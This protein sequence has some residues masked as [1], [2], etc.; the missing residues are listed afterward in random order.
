MTV[1]EDRTIERLPVNE[2]FAT[3]ADRAT[4]NRT[5]DALRARNFEA[6]VADTAAE[7]RELV[8]AMIPA[9]SEVGQGASV[10]LDSIGLTAAVAADRYVAI[11][12]RTRAMDRATQGREI[13]KMSAAPDVQL[14]SVQAVT[15]DGQI[16]IAS[17]TGSQLGPIASGAGKVIL[18]VGAQKIVPDLE[19]AFRRLHEYSFPLEDV[20]MQ[21]EFGGARSHLRKTLIL[22][23][24]FMPGRTTVV[25]VREP[26]GV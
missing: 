3:V 11:R 16:V 9:G 1:A 17:N 7:A 18:V 15:E 24:E 19:A 13:R 4:V 22:D 10:T 21:L 6:L 8:L 5:A 2:S 12:P 26:V 23:G 14:N 20:R 25:L